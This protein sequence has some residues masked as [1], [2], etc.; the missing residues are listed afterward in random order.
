MEKSSPIGSS[1]PARAASGSHEFDRLCDELGI[2]HRLTPPKSPQ[3]NGMVD[4][5][6]SAAHI[7]RKFSGIDLCITSPA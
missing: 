5:S 6:S 1:L 3:T 2:E 4:I 7:L